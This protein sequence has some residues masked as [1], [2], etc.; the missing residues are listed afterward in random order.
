[1]TKEELVPCVLKKAGEFVQRGWWTG[2]EAVD[3][4]WQEVDPEDTRACFWSADGAIQRAAWSLA[5]YVR[6]LDW[7]DLADAAEQEARKLIAGQ[8][9]VAWNDAPGR[10][11]G[12]VRRLLFEAALACAGAAR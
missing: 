7:L 1:M 9:L 10:C 2:V 6:D 5:P 8:S 4:E 11:K 12:A 3:C